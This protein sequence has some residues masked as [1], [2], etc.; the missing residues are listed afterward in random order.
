MVDN[1]EGDLYMYLGGLW[2]GEV[3]GYGENKGLECGGLG[4]GKEEGVGGGVGK[5]RKDMVEFGEEGKGVV[6]LDENGKG[7]RGGENEGGLLE[8]RWMEK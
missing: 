8:G 7:V 6:I 5:V 1:G 4:E 2:G 3:E